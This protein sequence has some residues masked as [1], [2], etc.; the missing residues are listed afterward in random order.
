MKKT[1]LFTVLVIIMSSIIGYV[2][3]GLGKAQRTIQLRKS[4]L[5]EYRNIFS[6]D[7]DVTS[8]E[9]CDFNTASRVCTNICLK[10]VKWECDNEL[11]GTDSFKLFIDSIFIDVKE[12]TKNFIECHFQKA[13]E[14][15]TAVKNL[16]H[17]A[18]G[19]Y[20]WTYK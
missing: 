18:N 11:R 3:F 6:H 10:L 13:R 16:Q 5:S 14:V 19:R 20:T 2:S 9:V 7:D 12:Q 4:I 17:S 8:T 1:V 15:C